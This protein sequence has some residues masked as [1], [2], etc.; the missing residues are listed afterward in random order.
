MEVSVLG[1]FE[2]SLPIVTNYMTILCCRLFSWDQVEVEDLLLK[3][4]ESKDPR[5]D[6]DWLYNPE[7]NLL[8]VQRK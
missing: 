6:T 8:N 7:R 1:L 4:C 5:S 2:E 3:L